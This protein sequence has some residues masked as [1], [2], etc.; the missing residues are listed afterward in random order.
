MPFLSLL[1]IAVALAMDAFAVA[2]TTGICL[3]RAS[4]AQTLRMAGAFGLFQAFM[5]VA[6]WALGLTV[7]DFIET[8]DHWAAFGLLVLVGG[9]MIWEGLHVDRDDECEIVDATRGLRLLMLSVA[10]SIDAL[11]VGLSLSLLGVGVWTPALVIGLVCLLF[12]A[13]G[14]HLGRLFTRSG[15]LSQAAELLGG[16]TLVVIGL[17]ILRGAGVFD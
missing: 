4:A 7:R 17:N 16:A 14:L 9:K 11:A 12:T 2:L 3:R 15:R 8:Y 1:V 5:P 13:C 6:G 10:T